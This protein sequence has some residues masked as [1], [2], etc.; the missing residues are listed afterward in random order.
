MRIS[1]W[2]ED[3]ASRKSGYRL[4]VMSHDEAWSYPLH[5]H[6]GCCEIVVMLHGEVRHELA[7]GNFIEQEAGQVLLL[8]DGD[9]HALSGANFTY[10]N[11]MF[12]PAWLTRLESYTQLH[13]LVAQ[14]DSGAAS[15]VADVPASELQTY[16]ELVDELRHHYSR[17]SGRQVFANFLAQTVTRYLAPVVAVD[18]PAGTPDWL[19]ETLS[20]LNQQHDQLPALDELLAHTCRCKEHVTRQFTQWIGLS[21]ARYLAKLR[22][23]RAAEL[24]STTNYPVQEVCDQ[25]GFAN[26]SYFYRLFARQKGMTPLAWRRKHGS[27]SIQS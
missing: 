12:A 11:I 9:S 7:G 25:V 2:H 23:D 27:R 26:E 18:I 24:L 5:R 16:Y 15:P 20:W 17:E 6:E 1:G 4:H 3:G 10:V 14:L 21:P 8:R 13:G 22:I 19:A